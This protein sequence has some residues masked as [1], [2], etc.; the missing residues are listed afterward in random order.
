VRR[1]SRISAS[2][3]PCRGVPPFWLR[4]FATDRLRDCGQFGTTSSDTN[5]GTSSVGISQYRSIGDWSIS[6][7]PKAAQMLAKT[8]PLHHIFCEG[9]YCWSPASQA[10]LYRKMDDRDVSLDR[11]RTFV[12]V[13]QR[14][15]L[16]AAAREL[17]VGQSTVT[18]HINEL[19]KALGVALLGRTTR[20]VTLTKEGSQYYA[21]SLQILR[22]VE[23]ATEEARDARRVPA[24]TVR[25][26]CTA[27]LGVMHVTRIIFAFQDEHPDIQIDL[28]LT[29]E[30]ID[31]AREGVDVALRLGPVMDDAMKLVAIGASTRRL[32]GSGDYLRSRGRPLRPAELTKH[33]GIVMSNVAGSEHLLLSAPDGT[34]LMVPMSGTL[35]VDNG[36]AARAALAAGRGIAPAHLWL[37]QDMLDTGK[38]EILLDEYGLDTVPVNL[39]VVPERAEIAR[40]RLLV[41]FLVDEIRKLPGITPHPSVSG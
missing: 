16:S 4:D 30:R 12:R 25:V 33:N 1:E 19:E 6:I 24:G 22:L 17:G 40:V 23:Q 20:R 34:R 7:E 11:M 26:S 38:L 15:S 10:E 36:L 2:P 21:N 8:R 27:A 39:L 3:L 35:R 41:D 14:G 13:A 29:D 18:R 28:K 5:V 32:A 37:I 9:M 31:L